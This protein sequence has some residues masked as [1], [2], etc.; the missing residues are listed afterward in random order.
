MRITS[1]YLLNRKFEVPLNDVRPTMEAVR[2]ALFSS[3]GGHCNELSVLDLYSG[4]GS[5]G[6][7]AWSRGAKSVTFVERNHLAIE[8]IRRN[9]DNL[10][11]K[12]LGATRIICDDAIKYILETK[13]TFNLI[14]A[15]PPYDMT[16]AFEKTLSALSETAIFTEDGLLV[17]EMRKRQEWNLPSN[18]LFKRNKCYGKTRILILIRQI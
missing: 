14:L 9:I 11:T 8:T 17:Y 7:E 15:D 1:G 12:E 16:D 10:K 6:L 2:E 4:T 5:L 13:D 18:W 3:L